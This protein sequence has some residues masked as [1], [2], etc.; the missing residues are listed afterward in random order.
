MRFHSILMN[1][2]HH[3][4][5]ARCSVSFVWCVYVVEKEMG[6]WRNGGRER[7]GEVGR[8]GDRWTDRQTKRNLGKDIQNSPVNQ[9]LTIHH[10][11]T[12]W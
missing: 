6:R 2:K 9:K 12:N 3:C 5:Y 4:M 1:T 8:K 7:R 11:L 10:G